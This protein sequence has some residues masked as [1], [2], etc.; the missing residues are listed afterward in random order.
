M[1][2]TCFTLIE[3]LTVIA[4]IAILA[5][6]LVPAF[7]RARTA[8]RKSS[9]ASNLKEIGLGLHMYI[10]DNRYRTPSC[11]QRPSQPPVNETNLPG[12]AE[13]LLP[14]LK[15]KNIF[16]CPA[17]NLEFFE[18]D[19]TSYEWNSIG[20]NDQVVEENKFII[21]GFKYPVMADYEDF[22]NGK[23]YLYIDGHVNS[24]PVEE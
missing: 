5:A 22:H 24:N 7:N 13:T 21:M 10:A 18:K 4:I 23:N 8:S 2:K 20:G 12:I 9:C 15:E 1:K 6:L 11:T 3:L 14:V 16:R 17:D 19:G